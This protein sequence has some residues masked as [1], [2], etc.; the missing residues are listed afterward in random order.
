[1]SPPRLPGGTITQ[2]L[3]GTVY[4]IKPRGGS[5]V[6]SAAGLGFWITSTSPVAVAQFLPGKVNQRTGVLS[7]SI[8]SNLQ[9]P[10]AGVKS[11]IQE[12]DASIS[13]R[14]PKG[15]GLVVSTGCPRS[16]RLPIK[17]TS[18]NDDGGRVSDTGTFP[19]RK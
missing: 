4:V 7:T 17:I 18:V 15:G 2:I 6:A 12:L 5:A 10:V 16:R 1:M 8:P 13:G 11:S 19:C 9:Q 3:K 14:D